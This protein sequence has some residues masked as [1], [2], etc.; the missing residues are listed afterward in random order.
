MDKQGGVLKYAANALT[1][2]IRPGL[3]SAYGSAKQ[4]Q[5]NRLCIR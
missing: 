4:R 2:E 5:S 3:V 1:S